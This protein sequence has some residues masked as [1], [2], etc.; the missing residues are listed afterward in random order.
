M[1]RHSCCCSSAGR[2][3]GLCAQCTTCAAAD[4]LPKAAMHNMQQLVTNDTKGSVARVQRATLKAY[5][6]YS[7]K[8]EH[9]RRYPTQ[10]RIKTELC[11]QLHTG[12]SFWKRL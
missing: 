11:N 10:N 1:N 2:G 5:N 9:I 7:V 3:Q 8:H 6:N 4:A 12:A